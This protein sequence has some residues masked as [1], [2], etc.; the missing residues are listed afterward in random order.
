MSVTF[1]VPDAPFQEVQC[2]FCRDY[3]EEDFDGKCTPL[4]TGKRMESTAPHANFSNY[5]ARGVLALLGLDASDLYGELTP[6]EIP[7]VLQRV[8]WVTETSKVESLNRAPVTHSRMICVGN[9]AEQTRRR[10]DCVRQVLSAA[11]ANG[12]PVSWG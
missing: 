3:G 10:L 12:W 5:N 2:W 1:W 11:V 7:A 8:M 4:C 9:T 6:E